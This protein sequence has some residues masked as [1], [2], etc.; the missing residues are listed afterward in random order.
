MEPPRS[1]QEQ[2]LC[3]FLRDLPYQF[4]YR[5][6]HDAQRELITSLFWSMAGGNQEYLKLFFPAGLPSRSDGIPKLKDAQGAVEGAEYTEGARGKACGH[7]FK[8]GEASYHCRTCSVDDTCCLCSKCFDATDHEGHITKFLISAGNSGCCDCGDPEAWKV[9][10]SCSIHS[11][12]EKPPD[13]GKGKEKDAPGLPEDLVA[14]MR[15]TIGR[16]LDFMLD[17]ISCSPEQLRQVKTVESVHE[18]E[19]ASRLSAIYGGGDTE[20]AEEFS[21]LLWNDEKHTVIDVQN[22]VARACRTTAAVGAQKA[23]ETDSIGRS[24]VKQGTDLEELIEVAELLEKIRVTVTIRS[25]RDT[26]REQMCGTIVEWLNDISGCAVGSDN[27]ILRQIICEELVL[28]SWWRGSSAAHAMV[29]KDGIDNEWEIEEEPDHRHPEHFIQI[30]ITNLLR[31]RQATTTG[32][33]TGGVDDEEEEEEDDDDVIASDG[34]D[35][36]F[37]FGEFGDDDGDEDD[38]D[39]QMVD[40]GDDEE[41][42]LAERFEME[43]R[44]LREVAGEAQALREV[45]GEAGEATMASYPRPPPPPPPPAPAARHNRDRELTPSDSDTAEPL[46]PPEVYVKSHLEI[47]KTVGSKND[48]TVP[49]KPGSYWLGTPAGYVV[50]DDLP[51][52]ENIFERVRLDW[53]VLFDVRMWKKVRI[54]LRSLYIG[55]VVAVPEFKRILGLRFAG[56]YTTLAQLYLVGD[57]EPDHSIINLSLQI[58]TTPSIT[59]EVVERCNF[60][61]TLMA[62]IYTF[63]TTRQVGYPWNVSSTAVLAFDIGSVTNRRMYHFFMDLRHLMASAHVQEKLRTEER[64]ILQFLDLVK[65]HQGICP[66]TRAVGEHVEYEADGWIGASLIMREINSLCRH[67]SDAFR[68]LAPDGENHDHIARALRLIAKTVI[69]NS[70]GAER[71]K[72]Q[73]AEIKDEVKFKTVSDF[74]FENN[75]EFSVVRFVVEEQHISFHH[76]LH[77]TLSYLIECGK[78]MSIEELRALLGFSQKELTLPPRSMGRKWF[79]SK[80]YSPEDLLMAAFDYPLRVCAWLAQMKAGMWV[81]NGLSLRH[82]A[83]TYRNVLQRDTSHQRDI[84]LLQTALVVCD[85]SRVLASIVERFGMEKWVKGFFEQKSRGQ[86]DTQHLDVVEDMIHLLIVLLSDRTALLPNADGTSTSLL[87]MRRDLIHVLCFKPLSFSDICQKLPN[88][89]QEQADFHNLLDE[90]TTFRAPEGLTDVGTFELKPEYVEE[91]DPYISHYSKNQREE[92]EMFYRRIVAKKT[93]KPVEDIVYEPRLRPITSGAFVGLADCTTTGMFAQIIY[94]SLLYPLIA[95][96]LTP[97]VP[98]TRVE[99]FLQVVLHLILLTLSEEADGTSSDTS[100][101]R[102]AL[103]HA[104]RSNFMPDA[105]HA[106]TIVALL[107]LMVTMDDFKACHPKI[108]LILKRMREWQPSCFDAVYKHLGLSLDRMDTA[109]PVAAAALD[110]EKEKKRKAALARQAKVMAQMKAQQNTF[111]STQDTIDWGDVDVDEDEDLPPAEEHKRYW[112]YPSETCILC[113]EETDDHQLYGSFAYFMESNILRTTDLQD[114]DF[115]REAFNVPENLDRSAEAIRPYGIAHENRTTITKVNR[116]GETVTTEVQGLGKGFP[117]HL[118]RPGP[119]SVGCGHVMHFSC[120]QQYFKATIDRQKTQIARH[121]PENTSRNEFVCP[122]CKAL[123]N[124]F[125]PIV[126]KGKEESYPGALQS[127]ASFDEWLRTQLSS[128]YYLLGASRP[129]DKV[130]ESF[131]DYVSQTMKNQV[132][133]RAAELLEEAWGSAVVQGHESSISPFGEA[134][135]ATLGLGS[136]TSDVPSMSSTTSSESHDMMQE[137]V[138]AYQRLNHTLLRNELKSRHDTDRVLQG[139]AV[140]V[141][142]DLCFSDI[143]ARSVGM[144]ISAVE[145]QQRGVEAEYGLT[146]LDKIPEQV[147]THLRTLSETVTSYIAVGGLM[148]AGDNPIDTEYRLDAE[149]QHCQLFA[150]QYLGEETDNV[151]RPL[152]AYPPLLCLDPF[153]FLCESAFGVVPAQGFEISHYLRA[154]YLAEIT[155]V[156]Y[157][158]S[159]NMSASLWVSEVASQGP[160][161]DPAVE[162][163]RKFCLHITQTTARMSHQFGVSGGPNERDNQNLGFSQP[164]LHTLDGWYRFVRNYALTFLRKCVVLL[165]VKYGV[166]F[167]N[168]VSPNPE[169]KELERLTEALRLPSFDEMMSAVTSEDTNHDLPAGRAARRLVDGWITHKALFSQISNERGAEQPIELPIALP[170]SALLSHPGIFELIGLPKSYG[171]LI[172]EYAKRTCPSSGEALSD[173]ML[174][175]FCGE[176][177]CGQG[178]CC[179][180]EIR[181]PRTHKKITIGGANQHSVK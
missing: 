62:I 140:R 65:L 58:L 73:Q 148:K 60:L 6:T 1:T 123:G 157:H 78:S 131:A 33:G 11:A 97:E 178:I 166:D 13:K 17:V 99:T 43:A 25:S 101:V 23:Y 86:D 50:Q 14:S 21:V 120:F 52:S 110:E 71:H 18:D 151:P 161:L 47:P 35:D 108:H 31:A 124:A 94:Y 135:M 115:V 175:L 38:E 179:S 53:L 45:A 117:S 5:N 10:M 68:D 137:L 152:D 170:E 158:M 36:Q 79:P 77:Y 104:G 26:F 145:I 114:G 3:Q 69:I 76:A 169:Q 134:Y 46:I 173:P 159:Q 107:N 162:E 109:S 40:V 111:M 125:L 160:G 167:N 98:F 139:K 15:M 82:Q 122:L 106:K 130:Q 118:C 146:F 174:C 75:R 41:V 12:H 181:E 51:L 29:G 4:S 171:T 150:G 72:F 59:A 7:I 165:Y 176:I 30:H 49:A 141:R 113:Q 66:N 24:I 129:K 121:Q 19:E 127:S 96:K 164:G 95:K 132:G 116:Q 81:R 63:L 126:W 138:S 144:S 57:R 153:L 143:L 93:G 163:F 42:G 92:A 32:D 20:P 149:R 16:I 100:F 70:I 55:T 156:V 28:K 136:G 180:K 39:V 168:H 91:I 22:Q 155:K 8:P 147:L 102:F 61:T 89:Y 64:Y 103:H 172:E 48:E 80:E 67:F 9:P 27:F 37:M 128:A 84:F 88:K 83:G 54:D 142:R 56:I 105:P 112:K 44:A 87:T 90:M 119:V 85:P 133:E 177:F 74:E 154:C 2:Q 34:L